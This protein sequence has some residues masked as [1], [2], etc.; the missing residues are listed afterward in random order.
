M[1]YTVAIF[2]LLVTTPI[3]AGEAPSEEAKR[4]ALMRAYEIN[5]NSMVGWGS[6]DLIETRIIKTDKIKIPVVN[7]SEK[8]ALDASADKADK[9]ECE[10]HGKRKVKHG[11][12]GWRCR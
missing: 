6:I 10:S 7:A 11:R 2:T 5:G 9:D 4:D 8:N 1:K 3:F 12:R